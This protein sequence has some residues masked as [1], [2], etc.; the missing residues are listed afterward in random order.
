M[1]PSFILISCIFTS[2]ITVISSQTTCSAIDSY[3]QVVSSSNL[4]TTL[5]SSQALFPP[6]KYSIPFTEL[7]ILDSS[8]DNICDETG[9]TT[10]IS[11]KIVLIFEEIGN[12]TSHYK[13]YV[14]EQN[15][16]IAVI[17]ANNDLSGEVITIIDDEQVTTTIPM[18]SIPREDGI[19]LRDEINSGETI[20][21]QFGCFDEDYPSVIC[22]L[23]S[24]GDVWYLDGNY[25]RQ[26][27]LTYNDH[28]VYMKEGYVWLLADIYIFLHDGNGDQDWYWAVTLDDGFEDDTGIRAF[29]TIGGLSDP[30]LCPSWNASNSLN[31][32]KNIPYS[33]YPSINVT[34][35]LC[36]VNGGYLCISS[37]QSN[38]AGLDGTYRQ[39]NIQTPYW[40][41]EL[42]DCDTRPGWLLFDEGWF[43]LWDTYNAWIVAQCQLDSRFDNSTWDTWKYLPNACSD[44]ETIVNG[45][46]EQ[47]DRLPDDTFNILMGSQC[48]NYQ[49]V[50]SVIPDKICL[51]RNSV[52]HGFIEGE[53][54]KTDVI[55]PL[56][57]TPEYTRVD[58]IYRDGA[59]II[60]Y[61]WW[62]GEVDQ[63]TNYA[64]WVIS[65]NNLTSAIALNG[66]V[67]IYAFCEAET[68]NPL[69]C[70]TG[71]NFY[72]G[73]GF[74]YDDTFEMT[75]GEC[76]EPTTL[77]PR[78]WPEYLCIGLVNETAGSD[79]DY[80]PAIYFVGGYEINRTATLLGDG[81][82]HWVKPYNDYWS[83]YEIYLYYDGFYGWWQIGSGLHVDLGVQLLCF[84]EDGYSPLDCNEWYDFYNTIMKNMRLYECTA[85][86]IL[87]A[88]PTPAPT[89]AEICLSD[90]SIMQDFLEGEYLP[91]GSVGDNYGT[92]E[93][94]PTNTKVYDGDVVNIYLWYYGEIG[95]ADDSQ[96]WILTSLTYEEG[97]SSSF[98]PIYGYCQ[99][100]I[101]DRDFTPQDCDECWQ[102]YYQGEYYEDCSF[103]ISNG[104][105]SDSCYDSDTDK[106][107]IWSDHVC[108]KFNDDDD[109]DVIPNFDIQKIMG[110]YRLNETIL[111]LSGDKPIYYKPV[112]DYTNKVQ[113]IWY[114]SFYN[115][116]NIGPEIYINSTLQC[117]QQQF[118]HTPQQCQIWYDSDSTIIYNLRFYTTD[119]D[120]S[121]VLTVGSDESSGSDIA[122]IVLLVLLIIGICVAAF[123][124]FKCK[125]GKDGN[126]ALPQEPSSPADSTGAGTIEMDSAPI[127][128]GDGGNETGKL[129]ATGGMDM[130]PLNPDE[131]NNTNINDEDVV[132]Q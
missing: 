50:D 16:G 100:S 94:A 49:C 23:D 35:G 28:P 19:I 60:I 65:P 109:T 73:L 111:R 37:E 62:Y 125:K 93:Y 130:S 31:P 38:L 102:F 20:D 86:D 21:I 85:D 114:D 128:S 17:L 36:P 22:I 47:D 90:S 122:L 56:M 84:Q 68:N 27:E 59:E 74:Y 32:N 132:P 33:D 107:V 129:A 42:D 9:I 131:G 76:V 2:W 119:C 15:G 45:T 52:M 120:E 40:F 10:D 117:Q 101:S 54:Y 53:Y 89:T 79:S 25:Q 64:W 11:N 121:D 123:W 87:T 14:A 118:E 3:V 1:A 81:N 75:S 88:S 92:L 96:R 6:Y 115:Y 95:H 77:E 67:A 69:D 30:S 66:S 29:C 7:A 8:N 116:W 70:G 41:R 97:K 63:D 110:G 51:D 99:G 113:Y 26:A 57:N 55:G 34:E 91:T 58:K 12:C 104:D 83:F 4:S 124:W 44:W 71:W 46:L 105:D 5:T 108:I 106:G 18:R 127:N 48:T 82:P 24:L 61:I 72:Y 13:V 39:F 78:T 103:L 80:L 43:Y 126:R 98:V 112:N